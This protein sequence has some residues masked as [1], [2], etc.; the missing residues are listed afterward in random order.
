VI[1]GAVAPDGFVE[2]TVEAD[3][4]VRYAR[5]VRPLPLL[6]FGGKRREDS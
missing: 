6:R 5:G 3:D 4:A 1:A 2:R